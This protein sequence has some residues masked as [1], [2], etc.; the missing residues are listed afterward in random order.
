M[1]ASARQAARRNAER[2]TWQRRHGREMR[3]R[4]V[5]L[6]RETVARAERKQDDD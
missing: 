1:R 4:N 6:Q 3:E 2:S 5:A